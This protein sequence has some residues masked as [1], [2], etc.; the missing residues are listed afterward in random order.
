MEVTI[1]IAPKAPNGLEANWIPTAGKLALP[2]MRL[3]GPTEALNNKI[4]KM[5]DFEEV[6]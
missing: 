1:Y 6:A 3:Y 2:A 4:F 5:R